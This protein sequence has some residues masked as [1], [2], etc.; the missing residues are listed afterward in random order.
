MAAKSDII[1]NHRQHETDTGSPEVQVAILSERINNLTEHQ[2]VH[3][4]DFHSRRGLLMLD[5]DVPYS[6]D[7]LAAILLRAFGSPDTRQI[8]GVGGATLLATLAGYGLAKY[9]FPG[10]RAVFAVI[11]GAIAVLAA[12]SFR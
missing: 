6:R 1:A 12:F 11:L 10:K 9:N 5:A 3:A 2:K 7:V 8:D 4:K